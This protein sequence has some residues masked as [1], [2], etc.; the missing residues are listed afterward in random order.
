MIFVLDL[1]EFNKG[2]LFTE[3]EN[4][5]EIQKAQKAPMVAAEKVVFWVFLGKSWFFQEKPSFP[6]KKLVFAMTGF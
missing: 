2:F 1:I 4:R 6:R 5:K 3:M